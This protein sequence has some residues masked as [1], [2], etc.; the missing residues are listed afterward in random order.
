MKNFLTGPG[1]GAGLGVLFASDRGDATRRKLR[2]R[3]AGMRD[4]FGR[5]VNKAKDEVQKTTAANSAES[6]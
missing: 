6:S 2:Y 1:I 4:D 5:K 3:F